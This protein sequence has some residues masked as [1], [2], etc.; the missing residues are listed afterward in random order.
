MYHGFT[1]VKIVKY[2]LVMVVAVIGAVV[3]TIILEVEQ[4]SDLVRLGHARGLD[5][6]IVELLLALGELDDLLHQVGGEGATDA[7]VLH[8]HH[9]LVAL[10]QRGVVNQLLVDVELGHV[11][12]DDG[13]LKVLDIVLRL[14]D[15]LQ[16]RGLP[17][18]EEA[19]K[20]RD[21]YQ[22]GRIR[23]FI[24]PTSNSIKREHRAKYDM[25]D[26]PIVHQLMM[27]VL[28]NA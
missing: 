16:Q 8:P 26:N 5:Q 23:C 25:P 13:G 21:R 2:Y 11:V 27:R 28:V 20:Q 6:D 10:D 18:P 12:D 14:E 9:R 3:V 7:T 19:A 24:L 1:S 22:V 4:G 15:V 17:R